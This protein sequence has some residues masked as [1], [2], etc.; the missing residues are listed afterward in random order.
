MLNA[1]NIEIVS[2][3]FGFFHKTIYL[4]DLPRELVELPV[5]EIK[6][7][8][9][10]VFEFNMFKVNRTTTRERPGLVVLCNTEGQATMMQNKK[11][12][13]YRRMECYK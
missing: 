10:Q 13:P 5:D 4:K 12:H 8:L 3:F 7:E 2:E 9:E 11:I 1:N 6:S